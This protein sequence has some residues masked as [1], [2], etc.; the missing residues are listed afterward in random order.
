MAAPITFKVEGLSFW[1]H[2]EDKFGAGVHEL[3]SP[4][5]QLRQAVL[6]AADAR[7]GVTVLKGKKG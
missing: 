6:D 7:V 3:K 5:K 2:G 1:A 4:S